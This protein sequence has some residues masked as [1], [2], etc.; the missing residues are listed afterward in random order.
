MKN[1]KIK[2]LMLAGTLLLSTNI[3][4]QVLNLGIQEAVEASYKYDYLLKNSELDVSNAR[5]KR[6]EAY[7]SFL[8]VLDYTGRYT[9]YEN[10][11]TVNLRKENGVANNSF[12]VTQPIFN[13]GMNKAKLSTAKY[14]LEKS[15]LTYEQTKLD[16]KL[17]TI[18]SYI[19]ILLAMQELEVYK[20]T[21]KNLKEQQKKIN[22]KYELDLVSKTTVLPFNTRILNVKTSIVETE[23]SL[24]SAEVTLKNYIGAD[25]S[26]KIIPKPLKESDYNIENIN[27]EK[28]IAHTRENNRK[29]K[30]AQ[31]D[32]EIKK[33]EKKIVKADFLPVVNAFATEKSSGGNLSNS[34]D[35]FKWEAGI[36]FRVNIFSFGSSLDAYKRS[37]NNV[38]KFKNLEEKTKNDIELNVRKAYLDLVK[39]KGVV[40]EQKSAVVSARENYALETRRYDMELIDGIELI[41][42]EKNLVEAER[43]YILGKYN[44][45]FA[46]ELYKSLVEGEF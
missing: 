17:K 11:T 42:L 15:Q 19:A 8:P 31:L 43:N 20:I 24:S 1:K 22:R 32:T 18:D 25:N 2:M 26:Y 36:N 9:R 4:A 37:K 33:D 6:N 30:I 45:Y 21:L 39:Y 34:G 29:S 7:K 13:G 44:Y 27:L 14:D 10:E 28:D 38:E 16:T 35:N 41:E 12:E 3:F 23:N 40:A 5:L 46:Y